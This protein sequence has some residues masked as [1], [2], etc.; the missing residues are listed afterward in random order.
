MRHCVFFRIV[1]RLLLSFHM[2]SAGCWDC[3]G[4]KPCRHRTC[5]SAGIRLFLLWDRDIC[6]DCKDN[7]VLKLPYVPP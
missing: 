2:Q 7:L 3:C 1:L 4:E 6:P 5:G